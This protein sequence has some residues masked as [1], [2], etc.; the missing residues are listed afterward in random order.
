MP[1][2]GIVFRKALRIGLADEAA[3]HLRVSLA[4]REEDVLADDILPAKN[5][6]APLF[7][8]ERSQE[9]RER[10]LLRHRDDIGRRAL[11]LNDV[12]GVCGQRR[13]Q[14]HGGSTRPDNGDCLAG[15]IEVFR[16]VLRVDDRAVKARFA[17]K[18]R[19]VA[20]SII[21]IAGR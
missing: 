10:I 3:H 18:F 1:V 16:P 12:R 8:E 7:W 5:R 21:I 20:L 13:Q 15:M 17:R 6:M 4:Q 14:G 2:D 19:P 11:D 9:F